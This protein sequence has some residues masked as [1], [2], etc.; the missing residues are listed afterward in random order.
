MIKQTS[1]S[2]RSCV[3]SAYFGPTGNNDSESDLLNKFQ[4]LSLCDVWGGGQATVH[5]D[6]LQLTKGKYQ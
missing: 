2:D 6:E 5:L 4:T 3:M 1:P